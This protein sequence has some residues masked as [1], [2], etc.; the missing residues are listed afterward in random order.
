MEQIWQPR[1]YAQRQFRSRA[2]GVDETPGKGDKSLVERLLAQCRGMAPGSHALLFL[3]PGRALDRLDGGLI[4]EALQ[5][6]DHSSKRIERPA[7]EIPM[8]A[9]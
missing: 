9:C 5:P 2:S 6:M 3:S 7:E 8:R 1:G 4:R